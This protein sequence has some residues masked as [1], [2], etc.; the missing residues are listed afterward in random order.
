MSHYTFCTPET[1]NNKEAALSY[2]KASTEFGWY[3]SM[4]SI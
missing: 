1:N 2:L 4:Q 3:L